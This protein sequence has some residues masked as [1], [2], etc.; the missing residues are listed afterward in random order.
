MP[1]GRL[2][3][4]DLD[5][6]TADGFTDGQITL[7]RPGDGIANVPVISRVSARQSSL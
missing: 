3:E 6:L 4:D 1:S 5:R 7:A 2:G